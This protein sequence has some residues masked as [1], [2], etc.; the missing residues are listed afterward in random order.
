MRWFWFDRFS[1]FV[2]GSHAT[3]V[4]TVSLSEDHLHDHWPAYPVMPHSLIIEGM[5]QVSGL[6]V[7]ES[8]KFQKVLV[9]AKLPKCVFHGKVRPGEVITY[10]AKLEQVKEDGAILGVTA[11]VAERLHAEAEI[12]F[13]VVR[14]EDLGLEVIA[15]DDSF[16]FFNPAYI[17]HWLRI[18]GFFE[19]GTT[20]EGEP[21]RPSDYDFGRLEERDAVSNLI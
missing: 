18:A 8:Y 21:L 15:G 13:A 12:F 4:K 20:A 17:L 2:S 6:L 11:H 19:V 16:R 9:L 3:A 1:E 14:A 7:G 10:R 5:A